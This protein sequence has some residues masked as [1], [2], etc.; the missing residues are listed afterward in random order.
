MNGMRRK[1]KRI[2]KNM[3]VWF[4]EAKN[5]FS[6]SYHRVF[7]DQGHYGDRYIAIDFIV[8]RR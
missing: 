2:V 4:E 8:L 6:E 5:L 3:E 1:M 7:W